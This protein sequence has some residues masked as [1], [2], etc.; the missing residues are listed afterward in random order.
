MPAR[1]PKTKWIQ[2]AVKPKNEGK[3][4]AYAKS[5]H[6]SM[7]KAIQTGLHSKNPKTRHRA[8]FAKNMRAIVGKR[9]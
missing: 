2:S 1:R 3:F 7:G 5:K 6:L 8:L 4:K 9:K